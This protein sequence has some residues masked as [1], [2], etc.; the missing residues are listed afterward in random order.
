MPKSVSMPVVI[1]V[2]V[3]VVLGLGV[4]AWRVFAPAPEPGAGQSQ[5]EKIQAM[6][7]AQQELNAK[8][9]APG[10]FGSK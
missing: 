6:K 4:L 2:V 1:G 9:K 8:D 3:A 10:L 7:R 5:A